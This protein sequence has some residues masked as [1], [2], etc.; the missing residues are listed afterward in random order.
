MANICMHRQPESHEM[1]KT[2]RPWPRDLISRAIY[3][4]S[5]SPRDTITIS[6]VMI[7]L[8]DIPSKLEGQIRSA[9]TIKARF[10]LRHAGLSYPDAFHGLYGREARAIMPRCI[11]GCIS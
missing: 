8:Y 2:R 11:D 4:R 3:P 9:N 10:A 6:A 5:A 7:T 1:I